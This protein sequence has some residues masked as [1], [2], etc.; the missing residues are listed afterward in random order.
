MKII[1]KYIFHREMMENYKLLIKRTVTPA[2]AGVI[3]AL[4]SSLIVIRQSIFV[5]LLFCLP[6]ISQGA[7]TK[8]DQPFIRASIKPTSV[9]AGH[10]VTVTVEVLA[11]N[12]FTKAP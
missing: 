5:F 4:H 2:F 8:I 12:W 9:T 7:E 11:P 1:M 3:E 6:H 10:P